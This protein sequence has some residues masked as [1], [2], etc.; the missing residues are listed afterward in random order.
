MKTLLR[1][2]THTTKYNNN[3]PSRPSTQTTK[4]NNSP[5]R[6]CTQTTKCMSDGNP[7]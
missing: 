3:S 1:L 6:P 7:L 2:H 5:S 4:Y